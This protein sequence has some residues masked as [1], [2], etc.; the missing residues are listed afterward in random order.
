[1]GLSFYYW[2]VTVCSMFCI[3]VPDSKC[4]LVKKRYQNAHTLHDDRYLVLFTAVSPALRSVPGVH[5]KEFNKYLWKEAR[6]GGRKIPKEEKYINKHRKKGMK[7]SNLLSADCRPRTRLSTLHPC[8]FSS[9]Q[10]PSM[11]YI[12][13]A[14]EW[15]RKLRLKGMSNWWGHTQKCYTTVTPSFFYCL[16]PSEGGSFPLGLIPGRRRVKIVPIAEITIISTITG[17]YNEQGKSGKRWN[18][19]YARR[20]ALK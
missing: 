10:Q 13:I 17:F 3:L 16:F 8:I 2:V 7:D 11:R 9:S 5:Q 15:K 19:Q 1:M 6:E 14:T 20:D 4:I 12:M 18:K